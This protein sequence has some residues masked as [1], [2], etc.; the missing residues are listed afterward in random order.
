MLTVE[1]DENVK[2][3]LS[4]ELKGVKEKLAGISSSSADA[5]YQSLDFREHGLK[6]TKDFLDPAKKDLSNPLL[7]LVL[8]GD[9]TGV[10]EWFRGNAYIAFHYLRAHGL[11]IETGRLFVVIEKAANLAKTGGTLLVFGVAN[12]QLN[13]TLDSTKAIMD[14]LKEEFNNVAK[15]AECCFEELVFSNNATKDRTAWIGHFKNVF[16]GINEI[17]SVVKVIQRDVADIK[18]T[19]NSMTLYERFQKAADENSEFLNTA[20]QFS[21]RMSQVCGVPYEKP[22]PKELTSDDMDAWKKLIGAK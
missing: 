3:V 8:K 5:E 21:Q 7:P 19:A 22:K 16:P 15:I 20:D 4:D 11:L 6:P 1:S 2:A 9:N 14:A 17:N 12:A 10:E 18:Q 13:A